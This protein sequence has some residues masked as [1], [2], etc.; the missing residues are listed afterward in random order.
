LNDGT[1]KAQQRTDLSGQFR[2]L[3]LVGDNL[4]DFVSGSKSDAT[5][6]RSLS[7][8]HAGRWGKQWIILPNPMYGDWEFSLYEFDF[9]QPKEEQLKLK[10]THLVP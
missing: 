5:A 9:S 2:L 4:D 10:R 3:L 1:A 7:D 6:R 8:Q